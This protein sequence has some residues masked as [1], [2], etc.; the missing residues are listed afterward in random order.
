MP[1]DPTYRERLQA[2]EAVK[3]LEDAFRRQCTWDNGR[4]AI[5]I[6]GR[7]YTSRRRRPLRRTWARKLMESNAR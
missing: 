7:R 4:Y 1:E 3:A 5:V 2:A 6:D